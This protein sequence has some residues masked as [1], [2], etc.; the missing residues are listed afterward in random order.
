MANTYIELNDTTNSYIGQEGKYLRVNPDANAVIFSDICLE[1]LDNVR[2]APGPVNGDVLAYSSTTSEWRPISNDPYTTG[3]GIQ[4]DNGQINVIAGSGGGLTSNING[5]YITPLSNVS[6][7]YGSSTSTP[8]LTINDKGQITSIEMVPVEADIGQIDIDYISRVN[9]EGPIIVSPYNG[10]GS[11]ANI[12]LSGTGVTAARYGSATQVPSIAVDTYGRITDV[13]MIDI[14]GVGGNGNIDLGAVTTEAFKNIAVAGQTLI[15]AGEPAD[16]L[17]LI[18]GGDVLITT[19]GAADSIT[20]NYDINNA[21]FGLDINLLGGISTNNIQDGD[22]LLYSGANAQL[23]PSTLSTDNL[24]DVDLTGITSGQTVTWNGS[25]LVASNT[26]ATLAINDLT[27]VNIINIQDGQTIVW[28]NA[29]AEFVNRLVSGGGGNANVSALFVTTLAPS[30]AGSLS[31]NN[32]TGEFTFR[33]ADVPA[34]QTLSLGGGS[35]I[36]ISNGNTIDI[37]PLVSNASLSPS[38]VT[39]GTYGDASTIPQLTVDV[40]GIVTNVSNVSV[41]GGGGST[42]VER[43]KL[44][45]AANGNLTSITDATGGI[46]GAVIESATGGAVRI[47]FDN[48]SYNYPPTS[49]IFYGYDYTNHKYVIVPLDTSTGLREVSA[50]GVQGAPTLFDGG[51]TVE[52]RLIMREADTGSSRG[53]FGTATHAWAQFVLG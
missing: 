51:D 32:I 48:T 23:E 10:Q 15:S 52:I 2:S 14:I 35:N 16:T 46:T 40:N 25:A 17:T 21:V 42:T 30:G 33:G 19:N 29:N 20:F 18:A 3:N 43:F 13:D 36:S 44:N 4:I 49:I 12:T 26:S 39:P 11:Q 1:F 24:T 47:T 50:G 9:G 27:D 37:G 34:D 7:A 45:Y 6:G 28:D 41:S 31:Y 53:D 22:I 5:I 38:G 8:V